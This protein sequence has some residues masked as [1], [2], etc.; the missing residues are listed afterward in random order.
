MSTMNAHEQ[1][2]ADAAIE[3]NY[4]VLSAGGEP[5]NA[6]GDRNASTIGAVAFS[7]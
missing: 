1:M 2:V 6:G 3:N 5:Y 7:G 4:F